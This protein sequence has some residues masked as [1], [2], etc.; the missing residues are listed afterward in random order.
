[1]PLQKITR[2]ELLARSLTVFR[3]RGYHN[4]A[5]S[6][7]AR[8]CGLFKGSFYHYFES[9]EALMRAVLEWVRQSLQEKVFAVAYDET[10]P[11][12]ERLGKV[13]RRLNRALLSAEGG[14]IV[15]NTTLETAKLNLEFRGV[16]KE[17]FDQWLAALAHLYGSVHPPETA[18]RLARQTVAELEG[19]VMLSQLYGSD[20][21]FREGYERALSRLDFEK[22]EK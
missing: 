6:D 15:G 9:K 14:C 10:L 3:Q 7:L 11:T 20:E 4:T 16:L 2:D 17:I 12:A 22:N 13:L 1:M 19:A 21:P 18:A 8:A 5:M